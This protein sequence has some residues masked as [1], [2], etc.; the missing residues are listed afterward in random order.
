M[1]TRCVAITRLRDAMSVIW[2]ERRDGWMALSSAGDDD[3]DVR[4]DQR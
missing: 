1:T 3:G 4:R 2:H